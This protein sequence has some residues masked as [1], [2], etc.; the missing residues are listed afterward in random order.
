MTNDAAA[1]IIGLTFIA[2]LPDRHFLRQAF[3]EVVL[4][5]LTT[6]MRLLLLLVLLSGSGVAVPVVR[7]ILGIVC[8]LC[9]GASRNGTAAEDGAAVVLFVI[10]T[11]VR[12]SS[13]WLMP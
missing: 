9:R 4:E 2:D 6:S 3:T 7:R 8:C 12:G 10:C 11:L 1:Y 5:V 13:S